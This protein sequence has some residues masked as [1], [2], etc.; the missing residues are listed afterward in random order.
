MLASNWG[1]LKEPS[2]NEEYPVAHG[3]P[4]ATIGE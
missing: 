2:R 4:W 3:A 1:A